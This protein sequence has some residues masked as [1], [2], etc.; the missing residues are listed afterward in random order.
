M[1][2]KTISEGNLKTDFRENYQL[3]LALKVPKEAYWMGLWHSVKAF[4]KMIGFWG[5]VGRWKLHY[6]NV[7]K[8]FGFI[9]LTRSV[10][11]KNFHWKYQHCT[12]LKTILI[13]RK[14][15]IFQR[16]T[17]LELKGLFSVFSMTQN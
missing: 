5:T 3:I 8:Y 4:I 13:S 14:L 12:V 15:K 10:L 2:E 9:I 7:I 17:E 11:W 6:F 16:W 1:A